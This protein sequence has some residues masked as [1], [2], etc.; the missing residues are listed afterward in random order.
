MTRRVRRSSR[1]LPNFLTLAAAIL[2]LAL[3]AACDS[4]QLTGPGVAERPV[5]PRPW[6][7]TPAQL[8]SAGLGAPSTE[9]ANVSE[10][11]ESTWVVVRASGPVDATRNHACDFQPP[12]WPCI[13]NPP[14]SDFSA[15]PLNTGPVELV[16]YA[17]AQWSW[18]YLR[19]TGGKAGTVGNA[20]GILFVD[21][22]GFALSGRLNLNNPIAYNPNPCCSPTAWVITGSYAVT[23]TAIPSP[24]IFSGGPTGDSLG[25][26]APR[27]SGSWRRCG[28][29]GTAPATVRPVRRHQ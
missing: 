6:V 10:L 16:R 25:R 12:N 21:R 8:G 22:A 18:V 13:F 5:P 20:V 23:A 28:C 24:L 17:G 7:T 27:P 3:A 26:A 1:P 14:T 29:R 15:L 11:P 19:G 4:R 9:W 2:S